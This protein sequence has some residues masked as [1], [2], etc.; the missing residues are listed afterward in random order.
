MSTK[1]LLFLLLLMVSCTQIW[2]MDNLKKIAAALKKTVHDRTETFVH[3]PLFAAAKRADSRQL[4]TVLENKKIDVNARDGSGN[5]ALHM[6]M[7]AQNQGGDTCIEILANHKADVNAQN[8]VGDTPL[9]AAACGTA[10]NIIAK[11]VEKNALLET[12]NNDKRTPLHLALERRNGFALH[13]LLA[14]HANPNQPVGIAG[15]PPLLL[16]FH[17]HVIEYKRFNTEGEFRDIA[18]PYVERLLDAGAR[19]DI[20]GLR[21]IQCHTHPLVTRTV[22]WSLKQA[23]EDNTQ[24]TVKRCLEQGVNLCLD[25]DTLSIYARC[26]VDDTYHP[27]YPLNIATNYPKSHPDMVRFL[28]D[29]G[30]LNNKIGFDVVRN[31]FLHGSLEMAH[32]LITHVPTYQIRTTWNRVALPVLLCLNHLPQKLPADVSKIIC[33]Y[34]VTNAC[35]AEQVEKCRAFFR[36]EHFEFERLGSDQEQ[37]NSAYEHAYTHIL[38]NVPTWQKQ[39]A[40]AI[41]NRPKTHT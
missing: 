28:I 26:H 27:R 12:F 17:A 18:D 14:L 7:Q 23:I 25:F 10:P 2:A 6:V 38:D 24:D 21:D 19:I 15:L 35:V 16:A 20:A 37:R 32:L 13:D 11:L 3:A 4:Q 36:T 40:H 1:Q 9:H 33:S 39:I 29:A 22:Y 41:H 5:T 30:A 31:A 8:S 34:C